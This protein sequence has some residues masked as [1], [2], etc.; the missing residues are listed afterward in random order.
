M[1]DFYTLMFIAENT[2]CISRVTLP[3]NS[4]VDVYPVFMAVMY[5]KNLRIFHAPFRGIQFVSQL[6]DYCKKIVE[7][8]LHGEFSERDVCCIV[9]GF[10][11][12]RALDLSNS[13]LS[14]NALAV[15]L[16]GR[17]KCIRD[18]NVLHCVFLDEE[19]KDARENYAKMKLLRLKIL[20]MVSGSKSLKKVMHCLGKSCEQYNMSRAGMDT[21]VALHMAL[22]DI[23]SQTNQR[24][25]CLSSPISVGLYV[26]QASTADQ[27]AQMNSVAAIVQTWNWKRF[28]II[29]VEGID[30]TFAT[31]ISLLL[32]SLGQVGAEISQLVPSP[33]FTPSLSE[34]LMR[35]R[36]DQSRVFVVHTSLKLATRLFQKAEQMQMMGK[37]Y[38]WIATNPISDLIHSVNLTTIFSMQGVLGVKKHFNENSPE[39]VKFKKRFRR[40]F[41]IEYPEEENNEPGISAVE[42]YDAMWLVATY[43]IMM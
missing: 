5:W 33:Y 13:T 16:D 6:M 23:R 7:L 18:L 9:E 2:P 24:R 3:A 42:A 40:D 34:E 26:V 36:N 32:E 21:N 30:S 12:L 4:S 25:T 14:V 38:A 43:D 37:D 15:I 35:L 27:Y 10:P 17:L 1:P 19:G 41:S 22:K 11:G 39:F 29:Y 31:V 28:T 8:G 20:E